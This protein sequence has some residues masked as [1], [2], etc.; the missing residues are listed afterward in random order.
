MKRVL[1][2][3]WAIVMLKIAAWTFLPARTDTTAASAVR[4]DG[5]GYGDNEPAILRGREYQRAGALKALEQPTTVMCSSAGRRKVASGLSEYFY[6]RQN[7]ML[8]YRENFGK[9]GAEYIARQWSS[10]D[11]RRIDRLVREVYGRG[12]IVP[13]DLT[14]GYARSLMLSLVDGVRVTGRGCA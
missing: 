10:A 9:P 7:Q 5:R 2:V 13:D 6:H 1:F 8:R 4:A 14:M 11:D 12:Y 3:I